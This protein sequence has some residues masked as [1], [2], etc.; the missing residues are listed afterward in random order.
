MK[1]LTCVILALFMLLSMA[2]C[3]AEPKTGASVSVG[4]PQTGSVPAATLPSVEDYLLW[5]SFDGAADRTQ[6]A[7]SPLMLDY[8]LTAYGNTV[9]SGVK[10]ALMEIDAAKGGQLTVSAVPTDGSPAAEGLKKSFELSEGKNL[11][12][13]SLDVPYGS[14]LVLGE[15]GDGAE[16]RI[17]GD[18]GF[19]S[20]ALGD[21]RVSPAVKIYSSGM[22]EKVLAGANAAETL[23]PGEMS[24]QYFYAENGPFVLADDCFSGTVVTGIEVMAA[25]ADVNVGISV[26]LASLELCGGQTASFGSEKIT[27][28]ADHEVEDEWLSWKGELTVPEGS[29]LA[30][31]DPQDEGM[32]SYKEGELGRSPHDRELG[33]FAVQSATNGNYLKCFLPVRVT[34]VPQCRSAAELSDTLK[35][36]EPPAPL[37]AEET[38]ELKGYLEGKSYSILGDSI[39]TY[40]NY[41]NNTNI[42]ST[43]GDNRVYYSASSRLL[44]KNTWWKLLEA[45]TAA[46][47]CVNNSWSGS[48]VSRGDGKTYVGRCVNLHRD[49]EAAI[50]SGKKTEPDVIFVY[51]STNDYN[52]NVPLGDPAAPIPEE[53]DPDLLPAFRV[54]LEKIRERY[55]DAYILVM[56]PFS[57]KGK[58]DPKAQRLAAMNTALKDLSESMGIDTLDLNLESGITY[59]SNCRFTHGDGLHPNEEG[60]RLIASAVE[61]ALLKHFRSAE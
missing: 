39:S 24:M 54:T 23:D 12:D 17:A 2:S 60:M 4:A 42:N 1:K 48:L 38:A 56:T 27:L 19:C 14:T 58:N 5:S 20:A 11:I 51:M 22:T 61:R 31:L 9:Y 30:F 40:E 8:G 26:K 32:L 44:L 46:E 52:G 41:S 50:S 33:F 47:L 6:P 36:R 16:L 18:G 13:V 34:G 35:R 15:A 49:T 57:I 21:E 45:D 3:A 55:P 43:I 28:Y 7:S 29:T 59:D 25:Y 37:T 10:V 53:G